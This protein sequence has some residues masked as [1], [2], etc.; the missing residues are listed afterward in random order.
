[1][2]APVYSAHTGNNAHLIREVCRLYASPGARIAD[3]TYGTGRF[4]RHCPGLK[5]AGSDIDGSL[6]A[7]TVADFRALPY[8]DSSFDVVVFDPPYA[9]NSGTKHALRTDRY[10]AS[11]SRYN[12]HA[13]TSSLYNAD[14]MEL[15]RGGMEEA[16][17]VLN[18]DGGTC[19]VKCRDEVEREVQRWSHIR[20]YEMAV[21]IGFCA[22]DLFV[23]VPDSKPAQRWPGR[24]Q[25]H[26]QKNHSFLWIFQRPDERY[27]K[28]LDRTP[29]SG[30]VRRSTAGKPS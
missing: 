1:M 16:Y 9:H 22:R 7:D 6:G 10:A 28:L 13:T 20:V 21:E 11:T 24:Q 23:L 17:R 2:V 12:G 27:R 5:V 26:A 4:W 15:Y 29:P 3:V 14:I 19:W 25:R 8:A 30:G 18:P